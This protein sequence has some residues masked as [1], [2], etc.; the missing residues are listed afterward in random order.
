M[1]S[2]NC[3]FV[4]CF[5][6]SSVRIRYTYRCSK[7]I[8]D[9]WL[10]DIEQCSQLVRITCQ[11]KTHNRNEFVNCCLFWTL[12]VEFNTK[13]HYLPSNRFS[14]FYSFHWLR[15][16]D[17]AANRMRGIYIGLICVGIRLYFYKIKH[18][19]DRLL[20]KCDFRRNISELN[21]F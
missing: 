13:F 2:N 10:A 4:F 8:V 18:S 5:V 11:R 1:K 16:S 3:K 9:V 17:S 15:E 19:Y 7:W 21:Q 14:A 20:D 6:L 12:S